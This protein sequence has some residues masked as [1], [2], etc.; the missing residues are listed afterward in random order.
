VGSFYSLE[1]EEEEEEEG[2]EPLL[3]PQDNEILDPS[4]LELLQIGSSTRG[5]I[6]ADFYELVMQ[7]QKLKTV[8]PL[9]CFCSGYPQEH[10]SKAILWPK[11]VPQIK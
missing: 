9:T 5:E 10:F 2:V 8:G 6:V 1:E 11:Q 4:Y 3:N 7:F